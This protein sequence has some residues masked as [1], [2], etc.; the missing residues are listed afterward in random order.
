M[1]DIDIVMTTSDKTAKRSEMD[2]W[3]PKVGGSR[4]GAAC[5]LRLS[6]D[7]T[8]PNVVNFVTVPRELRWTAGV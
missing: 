8:P 7:N 1:F 3:T 5:F 6:Y 4:A 2:K